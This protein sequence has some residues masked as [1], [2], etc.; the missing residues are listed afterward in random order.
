MDDDH[1][2]DETVPERPALAARLRM[3]IETGSGADQWTN[4]M[5]GR[6]SRGRKARTPKAA[7]PFQKRLDAGAGNDA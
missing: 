3:G 5:R 2:P 6:H 7:G 4:R 1:G